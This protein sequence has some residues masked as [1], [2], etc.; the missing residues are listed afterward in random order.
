MG[1][2]F[3]KMSASATLVALPGACTGTASMSNTTVFANTSYI[4]AVGI[5]HAL[6]PSGRIRLIL[7][8]SISILTSATNCARVTGTGITPAPLC[9]YNLGENSITLSAMNSTAG[10]IPVQTLIINITG[11][12][13]PGS[14]A[15]SGQFQIRTFYRSTDSSLVATGVMASVTATIASIP[16][17]AVSV[18]PS[19]PIVN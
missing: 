5:G 17:M 13:N 10:I 4:F 9:T 18:V 3:P 11:L 6:S 15:P 12:G 2:G 16:S 19:S 1:N 7:P 14:V 8:S